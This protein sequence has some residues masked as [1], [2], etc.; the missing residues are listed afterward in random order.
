MNFYLKWYRDP[1]E[2]YT[3]TLECMTNACEKLEGE[4][5][6]IIGIGVTNQRETT[7]LWDS[8]TGKPLCKSI[9]M[10]YIL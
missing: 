9:G 8:E 5:Y 3:N 10:F 2:I 6:E 7:V 1:I 4:D